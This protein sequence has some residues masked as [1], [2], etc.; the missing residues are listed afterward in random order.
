MLS[1]V[2]GPVGTLRIV[3]ILAL[4]GGVIGGLAMIEESLP[5]GVF[6]ALQGIV[7]WAALNVFASMGENI[8]LI[9]SHTDRAFAVDDQEEDEDSETPPDEFPDGAQ[10]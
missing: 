7:A 9:A 3:A 5:L 4:I 6:I 8:A 2:A 1:Q 10:L